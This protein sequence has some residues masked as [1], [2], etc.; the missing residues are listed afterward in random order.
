MTN[1]LWMLTEPWTKTERRHWIRSCCTLITPKLLSAASLFTC[2]CWMPFVT[3]GEPMGNKGTVESPPSKTTA[4]SFFLCGRGTSSSCTSTLTKKQN[5]H[6]LV[7]NHKPRL[8][9]V[10]FFLRIQRDNPCVISAFCSSYLDTY[11]LIIS[12]FKCLLLAKPKELPLKIG[13][14]GSQNELHPSAS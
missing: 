12:S 10:F 9:L 2:F 11:H 13:I 14:S 7:K 5:W 6:E 3:H 4:A 1:M 8:R